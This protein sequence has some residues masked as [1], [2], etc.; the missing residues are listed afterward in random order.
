MQVDKAKQDEGERK[1]EA[2]SPGSRFSHF[3]LKML[4]CLVS[5]FELSTQVAIIGNED[6]GH[7]VNGEN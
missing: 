1:G 4:L 3:Y 7:S 6:Q 2:R 5:V